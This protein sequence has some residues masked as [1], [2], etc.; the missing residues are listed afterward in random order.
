MSG[1]KAWNYFK[2]FSAV[3]M[4]SSQTSA[5][6]M[7]DLFDQGSINV[8]WTGTAAGSIVVDGSYDGTTFYPLDHDPFTITSG[9]GTQEIIFTQLAHRYIRMRWVRTSGTGTLT[10]E[11]RFK[12]IGA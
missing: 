1:R 8:T 3:T 4:G 7:V 10:A 2:P 12:S 11:G 9:S 5:S 6:F